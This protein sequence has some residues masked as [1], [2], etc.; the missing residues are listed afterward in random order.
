MNRDELLQHRTEKLRQIIRHAYRNVP[1]LKTRLAPLK[2]EDIQTIGDLEK[3]SVVRK[4]TLIDLQ[5]DTPPFGGLLAV[6]PED[7]MRIYSS[8]GP[9]YDP[10]GKIEDYGRF[11]EPLKIAGFGPGDIV[12]NTFSYHLS[13]AGFMLDDGLRRIGATVVPAGV[14]NTEIQVQM[15]HDLKATGYVGTPSFLMMLV[16]RAEEM[17]RDFTIEKA[18]VTAEPFTSEQRAAC[19]RHGIDV[20]QGYGTADAGSIAFECVRKSSMHVSTD[21]I[22]EIADPA[23]GKAVLPG[24]VGEVVVTSF[25]ETYPLIRFGLGDLSQFV[26]ADCDCGLANERIAG[27]MG[28]TG[29]GF[30]VRGMFV[31]IRQIAEVIGSFSELGEFVVEIER[32]GSRDMMRLKVECKYGSGE[33]HEALEERLREVLRVR[34]DQI[35]FVAVGDLKDEEKLIDHRTWE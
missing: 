32:V 4:E 18:Y 11:G 1:A 16:T 9:I 8:P 29:D 7:L 30:K 34:T 14:G 17:G 10:Q 20:Y 31:Y 3:I 5:A 27:F 33:L 23:T 2:P 13:P 35:T 6:E 12:M 21:F 15:I 26:E 19:D 22:L 28:R 24:E 25:N